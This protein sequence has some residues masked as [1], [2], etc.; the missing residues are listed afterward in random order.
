MRIVLSSVWLLFVY[1]NAFAQQSNVHGKITDDKGNPINFASIWIDSLNIGTVTNAQGVYWLNVKPGAYAGTFRS[2]GYKSL[3]RIIKVENPRAAYDVKLI[4]IED[5]GAGSDDADSIVRRVIARANSKEQI[6]QYAGILYNKVMQ[7]LDRTSSNFLKRDAAHEL[8]FNPN[9]IG[10][11]NLSE[12]IS[13]FHTRSKAFNTEEVIAAKA[14]NG[15][16]DLFRF[17]GPAEQHIDLYQN[18]QHLN[19]FNEHGFVSPLAHNA[20]IY[21]RYQLA[22]K[23]TDHGNVVYAIRVLPHKHDE[24]LFYGTIYII[25]KEWLLYAADLHLSPAANMELID[26]IRI[27]EQYIPMSDGHWLAQ[28]AELR[29]YGKF[30][31]FHYSGQFLRVYQSAEPDTATISRPYHEIF[32]STK[33]NYK[34]TRE[35]W[36][37]NRPVLLTPEEDRFYQLSELAEAS[38]KNKHII[39]SLENK[40]G[41]RFFPYLFRG[42]TLHNYNNNSAW[43]FQSP[44]NMGFYNTV[45]GWGYDIKIRYT[46]VYD[47]LRML[48]VIPDVRYGFSDKIFNA[49]IFASL[50]YNPFKQAS[51]YARVGSDF[52]DLNNKG[53]TSLFL[54]SISTLL[55]GGNYLK[56]YQ[57]RFVTAGTDGEIANGIFLNGAI[58]YADRRPA[59]NT[60]DH[61]FNKDSVLLTSNN[62]LDPNAQTPLFPHYRALII[63]GSATFTL[64]Q[65]YMITPGGKFILPSQY[66]RF[67]I[68]YRQGLPVLGS[69]VKYNFVSLDIFQDRLNLGILGSLGYYLSFGAF[70]NTSR[71]Y[72]PDYNQF[73]GGQGFF[74]DSTQGS[75]HFLNFYTYST[76]RPYFE[77]H[78]EHNFGGLFLSRIPLLRKIKIQEIV[79]G[80]YLT[81]GMLPDYKEVYFGL[82][83]TV[84]RLDYGLAY[85]RFTKVVQGF[86]L[87]YNF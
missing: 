15:S 13:N 65:E 56:L 87:V 24:H 17:N 51:V 46:R 23:F 68:S 1:L 73:R 70:P 21:Y 10:I 54:N 42:Y 29:Y 2:P 6:P 81:Q 61:T 76:Y 85:G 66:P 18:T 86:R 12:H 38:R 9:R 31:G 63:R 8:H 25:G 35:F 43:T 40:N 80:S 58:E 75:F 44:Y 45:E 62:P 74:F 67:R 39:D 77:A 36:A 71:L 30:W 26:S 83:R 84:V 55:L 41:F 19:G 69:D 53:T 27:R 64:D 47:S 48:T 52:L 49:N 11:L 57:S 3:T 34:Q 14:A 5:A 22:G 7:R 37:Q 50:V 33:A 72:Y 59:F 16:R 20:H 78:I 82:K 32:H 79:G 28:G 60:T 4:P